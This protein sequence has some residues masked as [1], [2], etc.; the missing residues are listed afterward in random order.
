MAHPRNKAE[1]RT[2]TVSVPARLHDYLGQLARNFEGLDPD[3]VVLGFTLNDY[4]TF[5]SAWP[6]RVVRVAEPPGPQP[7]LE[8]RMRRFLGNSYAGRFLTD[9]RDKLLLA[10][11]E[12]DKKEAYH[13]Q[14]MTRSVEQW[15]QPDVQARMKEELAQMQARLAERHLPV[16]Y[17]LFPELNDV[18]HP[19]K[20]GL[21]RQTL[22]GMLTELRIPVCD[23]YP[24]FAKAPDPA[25]LFLVN[26]SVHFTPAGHRILADTLAACLRE[27]GW[28]A[29]AKTRP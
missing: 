28:A 14:W 18:R 24:A 20:F 6:R 11:M 25:T 29:G 16:L 7:T 22:L 2:V 1:T 26:D 19:E 4:Q 15:S 21:A 13:T 3:A 5:D 17:L 9:L 12:L 23:P 8:R 27:A 10:T